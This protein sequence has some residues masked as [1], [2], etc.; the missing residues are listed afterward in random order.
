MVVGYH[1]VFCAY[2][3]WLPNDPRG[4]WSDFVGSWNLFRFGR[5]TPIDDVRSNARAPH[6]HA[7]ARGSQRSTEIPAGKFHGRPGTRSRTRVC[8]VLSEIPAS[9][10][11]HAPSCRT[12]CTWSSVNRPFQ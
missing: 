10:S 1:I 2:G 4:S 7:T 9:P 12:T 5:T 6:D 8:E 11:G 3:F